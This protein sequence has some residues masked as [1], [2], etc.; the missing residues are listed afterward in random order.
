MIKIYQGRAFKKPYFLVADTEPPRAVIGDPVLCI[1]P[2]SGEQIK[3][4]VMARYSFN[5]DRDPMEGLLLLEYG[6]T[7][8]TLRSALSDKDPA[9]Q[10]EEISFLII[11]ETT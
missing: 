5:W 4:E 1:N 2:R 11:K 7:S 10:K 3:G 8:A 6:V 9:F